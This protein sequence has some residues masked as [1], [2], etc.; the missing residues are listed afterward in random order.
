M[1]VAVATNI[2]P[3]LIIK[4]NLQYYCLTSSIDLAML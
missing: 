2:R 3:S 4:L 1:F